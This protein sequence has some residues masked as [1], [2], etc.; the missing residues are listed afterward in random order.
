[1][2]IATVVVRSRTSRTR[3]RQPNHALLDA[4]RSRNAQADG[5]DRLLRRA[6]ARPRDPRD[7]DA[8]VR[9]Q[10]RPSARRQRRRH[11]RAR[12][13][14]APRS[15]PRQHPPTPPSPRSSRRRARRARTPRTP[16]GRSAGPPSARRCRTRRWRS[17][18]RRAT[19]RRPRRSCARRRRT[20]RSPWRARNSASNGVVRPPQS[21]NTVATSSSPRR[22]Q[23][24]IS[25]GSES[26]SS[27]RSVAAITGS[28]SPKKRRMRR[29]SAPA[30][31]SSSRSGSRPR[32]RRAHMVCS[33]RGGPGST[34][35]QRRRAHE[36]PRR[37]AHRLQ[38]HRARPARAPACARPPASA[39]ARRRPA[40]AGRSTIAQ[41]ALLQRGVELHR[42]A[43]PRRH[44]LGGEVVRGRP[45]P[46]AGDHQV[47]R[48]RHE[49]QRARAGRPA[50]RRRPAMY[51]QRHAVP[52]Q[53]LGQPRPVGVADQPREH[54]GAGDDDPRAHGSQRAEPRRAPTPTACA[55]SCP[56]ASRSRP[57]CRRWRPDS[58][59]RRRSSGSRRCRSSRGS[60]WSGTSW[61]LALLEE[62]AVDD[63]LAGRVLDAHE[64]AVGR[65]QLQGHARRRRLLLLAS[66]SSWRRR[67]GGRR[68]GGRGRR[69][70]SRPP[71]R[72]VV[73]RAPDADAST[74]RRAADQDPRPTTRNGPI[75][76]R[77][78]LAPPPALAAPAAHPGPERRQVLRRRAARSAGGTPRPAGAGRGPGTPRRC[79][80]TS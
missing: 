47:R 15:A 19:R 75:G 58:A 29:S 30:E 12:P 14:R 69:R 36:E 72:R 23:V 2:C 4:P 41:I 1:M 53:R 66:T 9:A 42:H 54:L 40:R 39:R 60:A 46:A 13:R 35:D 50:G 31:A 8:D 71:A 17:S 61:S 11:L 64:H 57:A 34:H 79:A 77:W 68:R 59:C 45:E 3:A 52:A 67:G 44:D 48:P 38:H 80:G 78:P 16:R 51:G 5:P 32:P 65:G 76:R 70:A 25:S 62:P 6:A 74:A 49:V 55:A 18:A 21:E 37:R 73:V 24:V 28:G 20:A 7:P 43:H 33:S 22:R 10:P 63:G 26:A 27:S 56:A